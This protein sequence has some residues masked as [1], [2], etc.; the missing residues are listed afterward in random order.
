MYI[1]QYNTAHEY[2][3]TNGQRMN[4][5]YNEVSDSSV[6]LRNLYYPR[7]ITFEK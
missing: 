6:W 7:N 4:T 1:R 5:A 3:L 2:M